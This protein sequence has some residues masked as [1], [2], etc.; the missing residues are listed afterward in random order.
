MILHFHLIS[1]SKLPL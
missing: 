1:W